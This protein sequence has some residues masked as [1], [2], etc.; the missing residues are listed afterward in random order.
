M[1]RSHWVRIAG[2]GAAALTMLS[3]AACQSGDLPATETS[4]ASTDTITILYAGIAYEPL[5]IAEQ[6]GYFDE[7]GLDVDIKGGGPPQDNLAQAVGGSAD[8]IAAAWDTMVISTAEGM[9][10]KVI[11]GNSVVSDTVD[12][13]GVVVRADSGIASLENLAGKTVAF[14]SIGAGGT[15]EFNAALIAAGVDPTTVEIVAIP[16]AS[17]Q[18]SLE[19]GQVDAVFPSDPF[20]QQIATAEENSVI[21]NPVRETRSG[22]PIT[23][24]AATDQWL[25]EYPDTAAAFIEALDRGIEFYQDPANLDAVLEVRAEI[26]QQS[27]DEVST[28]LTDMRSAIDEDA[29]TAAIQQLVDADKVTDPLSVAEIVWEKTPRV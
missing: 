13:S 19:N 9:P 6:E 27:V 2:A 7:A 1:K 15:S 5:L 3:V 10:V 17:M 8:I 4:A 22:V 21:A 20:Y 24:W 23:L 28:S 11:S 29:T 14:D 25:Q 18:A 12:T 26:S 16:Y